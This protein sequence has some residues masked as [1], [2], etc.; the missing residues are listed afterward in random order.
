M[1]CSSSHTERFPLGFLFLLMIVGA[2]PGAGSAFQSPGS[3]GGT[4]GGGGG[5][6]PAGINQ[7]NASGVNS[8]AGYLIIKRVT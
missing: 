6:Y 1:R 3:A 5:S 4:Q 7:A 2:F 8:G